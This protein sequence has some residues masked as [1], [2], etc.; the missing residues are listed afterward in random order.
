MLLNKLIRLPVFFCVKNVCRHM[1]HKPDFTMNNYNVE[2]GYYN[3]PQEQH[4]LFF[5]QLLGERV[6][7]DLSDLEKYNVDW[8]LTYRGSSSVVLRPKSTEEVSQ[9]LEY[10][11][12]NKLAVC[13]QGGNTS[14]VGGSVPVFDEIILS[15]ELMDDIIEIDPTAGTVICQAGCILENLNNR[16]SE[17]GLIAPVDLGAKGSCHIGG[18]VATNAGGKR[19]LRY[20]NLHGNVLGL[21]VVKANGEIIDSLA[22][23]KKNNTGF[24][25]K[26][27]FIGS[28]GTLGLITKVALLCPTL[29][30]SVNVAFLGCQ[31][32]ERVLQTLKKSK[33]DLG[34]ILSAFEVMDADS[35]DLLERE[36]HIKSPIGKYPFY[37]LIETSGSNE[38]HDGEKVSQFLDSSLETDLVV[39]G[40]VTNE[41]TK[42]E[43]IWSIREKIPDG[44]RQCGYSYSYDVTLPLTSFFQIVDDTKTHF[45]KQADV[46]C[47]FGHLGDGNL[48]LIV[49]AHSYDKQFKESL[50]AFVI[51]KTLD[52][53]GS[54]SA[55]HGMGFQKAKYLNLVNSKGPFNMMKEL[56]RIM[57]PNRILNPYK[58][59]P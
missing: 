34:E 42:V 18:N 2:R 16:L 8:F 48:H 7:T 39:N 14:V 29:P 19:L 47:G 6:V 26:N 40:T 4:L 32:Y 51:K 20:G 25:I 17:E 54:I 58:V 11:N 24:H 37:V 56:K 27:L 9:I 52:L 44:I 43:A 36:T 31:N 46:V 49:T 28:E 50:E 3:Y 23:L 33:E 21:E 5:K 1:G 57:D 45:G 53:R 38:A 35:I 15:T 41:P 13:P 30:K 22:T 12:K 59:F 10:C 55:E